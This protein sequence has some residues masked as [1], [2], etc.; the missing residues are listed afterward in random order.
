VSGRAVLKRAF[1]ALA[2]AA[3]W[4]VPAL[5]DPLGLW[6]AARRSAETTRNRHTIG[7][8]VSAR[9]DLRRRGTAPGQIADQ[10]DWTLRRYGNLGC[11]GGRQPPCDLR[12]RVLKPGL[13]A[14]GRPYG[15]RSRR[16]GRPEQIEAD[17]S[18]KQ[19]HQSGRVNA[20]IHVEGNVNQ[21]NRV[22]SKKSELTRSQALGRGSDHFAWNL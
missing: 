4:T 9:D 14:V 2:L 22:R 20:P 1:A 6:L 21:R 19:A 15:G 16:A 10:R 12:Q 5:A 8:K 18:R 13:R 11:G 3:V 17:Q 7:S